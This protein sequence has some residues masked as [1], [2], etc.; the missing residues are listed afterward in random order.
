MVEVSFI[1]LLSEIENKSRELGGRSNFILAT[2]FH[3]F[4][5]WSV[6]NLVL[7]K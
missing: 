1:V 7:V 2:L 6:L 5:N 4:P 3:I